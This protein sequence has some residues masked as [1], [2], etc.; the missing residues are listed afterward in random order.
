MSDNVVLSD[1][2][3][4]IVRIAETP[5]AK[6][7]NAP[8]GL[9]DDRP[10]PSRFATAVDTAMGG[11]ARRPLDRG[12]LDYH[13]RRQCRDSRPQA[14]LRAAIER[15][16]CSREDGGRSANADETRMAVAHNKDTY[17][18]NGGLACLLRSRGKRRFAWPGRLS[19]HRVADGS[20]HPRHPRRAHGAARKHRN[21]RRAKDSGDASDQPSRCADA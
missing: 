9:G 18:S 10:R 8:S 3:F 12:T 1:I 4:F 11:R 19:L 16:L 5:S 21:R 17:P 15:C 6:P 20:C 13:L 2:V 7:P 14:E